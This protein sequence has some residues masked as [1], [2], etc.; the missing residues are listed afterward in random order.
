MAKVE[1]EL[2][3]AKR[4]FDGCMNLLDYDQDVLY[5][6]EAISKAE[7]KKGNPTH[8]PLMRSVKVESQPH[9]VLNDNY[10]H[11]LNA[12]VV[13]DRALEARL[14]LL[15]EDAKKNKELRNMFIR[16]GVLSPSEL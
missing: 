15:E 11:N 6:K 3:V 14:A 13:I 16:W 2:E 5:L 4:M 1:L 7:L 12:Q 9:Y 10:N 8:C